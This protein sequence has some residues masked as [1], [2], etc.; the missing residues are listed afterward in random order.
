MEGREDTNRLSD[1]IV[2]N[3]DRP[4][5]GG[6]RKLIRRE[7]F[8][9]R[10]S[11]KDRPHDPGGGVGI[12]RGPTSQDNMTRNLPKDTNMNRYNKPAQTPV[13]GAEMAKP[14]FNRQT[15]R[16][17]TT[18]A[19][20][21]RKLSDLTEPSRYQ[22]SA[23][24]ADGAVT[25]AI[26][27]TPYRCC[28]CGVRITAGRN[29]VTDGDE[30]R[31]LR[32]SITCQV[33]PKTAP[34]TDTGRRQYRLK[35]QAFVRKTD[36]QH[37]RMLL[38]VPVLRM[39][40]V[41]LELAEEARNSAMVDDQ[42]TDRKD[43]Q[44]H[45]TG[46]ARPVFVTEILNSTPVL[47]SRSSRVTNTST[48]MTPDRNLDQPMIG[49]GP[50][51]RDV[52][53]T[54]RLEMVARPDP[55]GPHSRPEQSVSLRFD[56]DQG[57]HYPTHGVHPGVKMF[58]T[59]PVADGP[60]GPDRIRHPV[61]TV[62]EMYAVHDDVRPTAG[63]PV[64]RF[65]VPGPLKYS[66]ISS[67]DDSYQPLFTGP[68]GTNEMIAMNDQS[69]P[70][71]NGP[72]A[73]Q[74]SLDPMGPRAILSL[75]DKN[76]PPI[77]GPVGRPWISKRPR[78]QVTES[79]FKQTTQTRSESES[80]TGVTDS[81]IRTESDAQIDRANI[82]MTNGLTDSNVISSSSDAD[83][84]SLGERLIQTKIVSES[85]TDRPVP[86][87]QTE[88]AVQI[89]RVNIGVAN[90]P[91]DSG[92]T[93]PSSDSGIHSLGEQW[94][95]MSANSMSTESIQTVKN[96][97]GGAMNQDRKNPQEN[98]KVGS[99]VRTVYGKNDSMNYSTTD[100]GNS[101]IAAMSDFSDEDDGP[102]DEIRP[103][104]LTECLS[105]DSV[106][107]ESND[108]ARPVPDMS[109]VGVGP[110]SLDPNDKD[111]W[112]KFRLLTRQAFL[113]DNVKLSESDYPDAVKEVVTRSRLTVIEFNKGED[114]PLEQYNEGEMSDDS[115]VDSTINMYKSKYDHNL[116][117]YRDW[118]YDRAPI[119]PDVTADNDIGTV[120]N[121][122]NNDGQCRAVGKGNE[123]G[124]DEHSEPG[125]RANSELSPEKTVRLIRL[126]WTR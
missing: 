106:R 123:V 89:D 8:A 34:L 4:P 31:E 30:G 90:G 64:G 82:C 14:A 100:S 52:L 120:R 102:K 101:D 93:P 85:V 84:H 57:E 15:Q 18:A 60:A 40:N 50:V 56:A 71:A 55:V 116:E 118:H 11:Y 94:E 66:K 69:R 114:Q 78:D 83:V 5:S 88:C 59:Q 70:A 96:F 107:E 26:L 61:G 103:L 49:S 74:C 73:R 108:S 121:A 91:T 92:V 104:L 17:M 38:E 58:R 42:L 53:L 21:D 45:R 1:D 54:G 99:F 126:V 109:T 16:E 112:T 2:Q 124:T 44:S 22:G 10:I 113:L 29:S 65:P 125:G 79:G 36:I 35:S 24:E 63:G 12:A 20:V 98:R 81:V 3:G 87:I 76:Q 75:G 37:A 95:N 27:S 47:G 97:Y 39:P 122:D 51:G 19:E 7:G 115:D 25:G 86:V 46:Q 111:Y 33:V 80:E 41:F 72:L 23:V 48:E 117:D 32:P 110:Y 105:D 68:L 28:D 62:Y 43:V 13:G 9:S 119:V 6:K 77:V 67:P